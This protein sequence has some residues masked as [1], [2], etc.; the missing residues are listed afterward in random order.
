MKRKKIR[1]QQVVPWMLIPKILGAV[2][3][4]HGKWKQIEFLGPFMWNVFTWKRKTSREVDFR[5]HGKG[6]NQAKGG[7]VLL[8]ESEI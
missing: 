1:L 7:F 5:F 6:K 2:D 8:S 3:C 4:F